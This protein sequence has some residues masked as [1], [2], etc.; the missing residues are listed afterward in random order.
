MD[1][2]TNNLNKENDSAGINE[3]TSG[4]H[5]STAEIDEVLNIFKS[6]HQSKKPSAAESTIS[7]NAL[8]SEN[9][10]KPDNSPKAADD[11]NTLDTSKTRMDLPVNTKKQAEAEKPVFTAKKAEN[12][13]HP[14]PSTAI[15]LDDFNSESVKTKKKSF[16]AKTVSGDEKVSFF[17][18]VWF[19]IIKLIIYIVLVAFAANIISSTLISIGNDVFA[20]KKNGTA[21]LLEEQNVT[22]TIPEGAS[23]ADV[24]KILHKAGVIKHPWVFKVYAEFRISRRSY[25]T[26]EYISGEHTVNPMM[27]FDKLINILSDYERN[28]SGTVRI[29]FPEGLTV[30]ETIELLVKNGVGKKE[31]YL[32]ALQS[33]E[34][35][36]RFAKEL[37][38]DKI[39]EYRFDDDYSYRLEGYLF[40]DTYDFYLNENPVSVINKFLVNFDKKFEEELYTRCEQLGLTVDEVIT[41][42]S[43]IEKEGRS[44]EEYSNIS[45]VFHNRLKN[46][47][48]FPYL[49]SDATLQ[50]ALSERTGL[51]DLDTS[52]VHPYNTYN[53]KGLP[54]GPICNPGI[55]AIYD[56]LY[57]NEDGTKYYYFYTKKNG[58]TVF[59]RTYEQHQA[60]VNSDR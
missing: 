4:V 54:P 42:A 20:F 31:D 25:L 30:N 11:S 59:S 13:T 22:I 5:G 7:I 60:V 50:Y 41:I 12:N 16:F 28:V 15:S 18:S 14:T 43:M 49:N 55:Q 36:Y 3:N 26:G 35:E 44:P 58:T 32:E 1:N 2:N 56:A 27:N 34:Y 48:S 6:N 9:T 29:T 38:Q 21:V 45:A 39:S 51:Y 37:T 19:G 17:G 24:G 46:S 10:S 57:P 53:Q 33:F 47:A 52:L 8:S 23:T 40:P